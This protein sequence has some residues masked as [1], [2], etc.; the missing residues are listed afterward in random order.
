MFERFLKLKQGCLQLSATS[1]GGA[2]PFACLGIVGS[3]L[4]GFLEGL[5]RARKPTGP[6]GL[7][8]LDLV[9][10]RGGELWVRTASR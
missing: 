8:P 2:E 3:E 9:Q 6:D 10:K 1:V 5:L 4:D 7:E